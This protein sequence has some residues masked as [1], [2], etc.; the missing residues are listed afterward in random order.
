VRG[1]VVLP[2]VNDLILFWMFFI[3]S[4]GFHFIYWVRS[5]LSDILHECLF[6]TQFRSDRLELHTIL[7]WCIKRFWTTWV[8]VVVEVVQFRSVWPELHIGLGKYVSRTRILGMR[9]L[10]PGNTQTILGLYWG[11]DQAL[12]LLGILYL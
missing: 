10:I 3:L 8:D 6:T 2:V 5:T 12:A 11:D 9:L 4:H 1:V 7:L